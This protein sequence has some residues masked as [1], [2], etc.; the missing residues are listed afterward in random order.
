MKCPGCGFDNKP[1]K[2]FC[3][4]CGTRLLLKCPKCGSEVEEAD[5][6]CGQCG[7]DLRKPAPPSAPIDY[8]QPQ[9]YTPNPGAA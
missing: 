9:S 7:H 8:S 3:T 1:D 2:R 4:K 5:D 6:F